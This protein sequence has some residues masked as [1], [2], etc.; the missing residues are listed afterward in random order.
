MSRTQ[1]FLRFLFH[2]T[3]YW[4]FSDMLLL[5]S[6]NLIDDILIVKESTFFR[7]SATSNF[8]S[9]FTSQLTSNFFDKFPIKRFLI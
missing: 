6:F 4:K 5:T 7:H 8:S 1:I 9:T 3:A 2:Y